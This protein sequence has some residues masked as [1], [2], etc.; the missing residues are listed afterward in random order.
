MDHDTTAAVDKPDSVNDQLASM[1]PLWISDELTRILKTL[2]PKQ[3][4]VAL[5]MLCL[6][7][8]EAV[9]AGDLGS[10]E[11][12]MKDLSEYVIDEHRNDMEI[13]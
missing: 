13:V 11:E 2:P 9:H 6:N 4:V 10:I 1:R 8:Y 5:A 7:F 3:A 12:F